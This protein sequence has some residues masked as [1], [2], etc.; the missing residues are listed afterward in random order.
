M[1]V[2]THTAKE[3]GWL[4]TGPYGETGTSPASEIMN[5]CWAGDVAHCA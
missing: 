1:Q 3:C 4:L 2:Q 5:E